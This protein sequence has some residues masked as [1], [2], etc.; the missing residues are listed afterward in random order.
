[1]EATVKY[2]IIQ[3]MAA[4][5]FFFGGLVITRS[6]YVRNMGCLFGNLGELLIIFSV[7]M[8]LGLAPFHY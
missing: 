4:A 1:M 7:I 2:F 3:A 6:E 8:K 5:L